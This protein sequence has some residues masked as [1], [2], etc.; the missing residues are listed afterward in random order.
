MPTEEE[1]IAFRHSIVT[2]PADTPWIELI[3][4]HGK[5]DELEDWKLRI[6]QETRIQ[7]LKERV[8]ML[9]IENEVLLKCVGQSKE[10]IDELERDL[11]RRTNGTTTSWAMLGDVLDED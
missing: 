5:D 4:T 2:D 7:I 11:A 10:R 3:S 1:I 6:L 9:W 8:S